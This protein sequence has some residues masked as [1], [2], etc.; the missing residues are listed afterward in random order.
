MHT[1]NYQSTSQQGKWEFEFV[2]TVRQYMYRG[3]SH[4]FNQANNGVI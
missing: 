3:K 1:I 2:N 4:N